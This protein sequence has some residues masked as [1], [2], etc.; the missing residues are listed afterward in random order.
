M[1]ALRA[2][3]GL[4]FLVVPECIQE[5]A[6]GFDPCYMTIGLPSTA[7]GTFDASQID[8]PNFRFS[9]YDAIGLGPGLGVSESTQSLVAGIYRDS[10]SPVV[11]DADALNAMSSASQSDSSVWSKHAGVRIVTPHPGEFARMTGRSIA[12][13]EDDRANAA[14]EFAQQHQV[15]VVLKGA[16]TVVTDGSQLVTNTSGNSG[17]ATGGSGDVLTG[18][19]AALVGQGLESFHAAR[20]GVWLHGRAGDLA[21]SEL[22]EAG[23]IASDLPRFLPAAWKELD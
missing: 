1:G 11:V 4:V 3:A 7:E 10:A 18:V 16:G 9:K 20:L 22:S 13:I 5:I 2:G 14:Q 19:I 12:E 23:L 8:D 15:I 17:M 6:A 21:A